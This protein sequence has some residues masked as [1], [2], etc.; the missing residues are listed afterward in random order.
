[1]KC[2]LL[3]D[4]NLP[5]RKKF[6][7]LNNRYN[8]RH[9]VHDYHKSGISDTELFKIA[10]KEQRIILTRNEKDFIGNIRKK[11]GLI[12]LSP[13]LSTEDIDKKITSVL[14]K[15]KR[16]VLIGKFLHIKKK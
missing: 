2:R 12:G 8:V 16:C 3:L 7:R 11:S 6:F 14:T 5:P 1:M 9:I 13:N 15:Y 10:E 4:E